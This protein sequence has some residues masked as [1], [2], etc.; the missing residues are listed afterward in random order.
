MKWLKERLDENTRKNYRTLI[1]FHIPSLVNSDQDNDT[2]LNLHRL[3][4]S[5]ACIGA[6]ITGHI[7]NQQLYAPNV[8]NSFLEQY[9]GTRAANSTMAYVVS[10]SGGASLHKT[11][12]DQSKYPVNALFPTA[13]EWKEYTEF[14]AKV[15]G[16]VR[17]DR[18]W[19]AN[20][21]ADMKSAIFDADTGQYLSLLQVV[22]SG[23]TARCTPY[24]IKDIDTLYRPEEIVDIATNQPPLSGASVALCKQGLL[25]F[26]I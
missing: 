2:L 7:H 26:I 15:L 23:G 11:D 10:G 6:V 25:S 8:W 14:A 18:T 22:V 13:D 20:V 16:V 5:Y 9:I 1:M 12:F 19:I 3:I 24:W 21:Y 17:L 4:A